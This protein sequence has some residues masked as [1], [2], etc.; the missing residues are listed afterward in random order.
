MSALSH[1]ANKFL[2]LQCYQFILQAQVKA[3]IE[4]GLPVDLQVRNLGPCNIPLTSLASGQRFMGFV[5]VS[6]G[7]PNPRSNRSKN[8]K[9]TERRRR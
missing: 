1:E 2:Y 5:C 9:I 3:F 8:Q 7:P 4:L 6:V